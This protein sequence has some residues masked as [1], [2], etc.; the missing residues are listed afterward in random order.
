MSRSPRYLIIIL[1]AVVAL[2][3]AAC[4]DDGEE[5]SEGT[6]GGGGDQGGGPA[7]ICAAAEAG[8][9]EIVHLTEL[10]GESE[11][12]LN[13]FFDGSTLAAEEINERCGE[14]VVS[15]ERIPTDVTVEGMEESLL[16]A[17]DMEP[18]A[19]IGQA[20]SSQIVLNS[21]VD[22]A[23]IP[24]LWP[25]A[26]ESG[27]LEGEDGSE[28]AWMVRVINDTQGEI[29]GTHLATLENV[30][31]V[32]LECVETQFGVSGCDRMESVLSENDI[33]VAGRGSSS[34]DATDFTSSIVDLKAAGADA[35]AMFT[36]PAS[37]IALQQ[38][39]E[40]N[41]ALDVTMIG[42]ASTELIYQ[43][44]SP[45]Q[46]DATIAL[47]DCNPPEESPEVN[48]RYRGAYDKNM[49]GLAAGTYDAVFLVVDAVAREGSADP[50]AVQSGLESTEWDGACQNYFDSG[51][52]ALAHRAVV[53]S[54][55][56][57]EITTEEEYPLNDAGT[58][59]QG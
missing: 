50:D 59:L 44:L 24:L 20:S 58:G 51:N 49:T 21:L 54:F 28:W 57:G 56:G 25:V 5:G 45:A 46:Q 16:E 7:D 30:Q 40:D 52:R 41:D 18:T 10:E 4:G 14:E 8:P 35:L 12:G 43:A 34:L 39:M 38:Q 33:Q 22:E 55:S 11:Q 32:W 15:L 3:A 53:T 6:N 1:L 27:T 2:V 26:T 36:F 29:L 9:V 48:E 13:D 17:Q 23:G 47:A 37:Q 31:S 42:G 19:I